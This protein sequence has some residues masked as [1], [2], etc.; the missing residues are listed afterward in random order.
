MGWGGC[1]GPRSQT[2]V[3]ELVEPT[4]QCRSDWVFPGVPPWLSCGA[5]VGPSG[6]RFLGVLACPPC[7]PHS[8]AR[9]AVLWRLQKLPWLC[10]HM[11][12]PACAD[13]GTTLSLFVIKAALLKSSRQRSQG[14]N[15]FLHLKGFY[16]VSRAS[17]KLLI[18]TQNTAH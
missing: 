7:C 4:P 14:R 16:E 2:A 12:L 13:S 9:T 17:D 10:A 6:V 3:L 1:R 15:F 8:L 5:R 18:G 11:T